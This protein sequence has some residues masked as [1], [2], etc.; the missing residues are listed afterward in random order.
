MSRLSIFNKKIQSIFQLLGEKE[1]DITYS[2]AYT[3]ANSPA[4]LKYFLIK[5]TSLADFNNL[6]E[7]RIEL[8]NFEKQYGF[9]DFEVILYE[10]FYLIIEA[11]K[12]FNFPNDQQLKMYSERGNF[13]NFKGKVKKI[14]VFTDSNR[15]FINSFFKLKEI[16]NVQIEVL[17][18]REIYQ[19]LI[20]SYSKG[21]NYEKNLNEQLRVYLKQIITMQKIDSNWVYVV[22]LGV[23]KADFTNLNFQEV[24]QQKQIYFHPVG[25]H[26]PVEPVNYIAFS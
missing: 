3:L 11:K 14:I 17:S 20:E 22:P 10:D 15:A 21:N 18:Y 7:V 16:N 12:G 26:Y 25:N 1:N 13:K 5:V 19:M 8:Q 6:E 2:I 9:T 24:V 4:F 23:Q